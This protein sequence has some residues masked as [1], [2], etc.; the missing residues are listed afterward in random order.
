MKKRS[1]LFFA[2]FYLAVITF[3]CALLSLHAQAQNDEEM[4]LP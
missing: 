1:L 3:F 2:K 4:V